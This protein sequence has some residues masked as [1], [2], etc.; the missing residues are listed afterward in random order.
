[1]SDV[2]E[3]NAI[4]LTVPPGNPEAL[5]AAI[6]KL[7]DNYQP[8][9]LNDAF[10]RLRSEYLWDKV[11]QPLREFCENPSA[12]PDKGQYLTEVERISK[13]KDQFLMKVIADKDDFWGAVVKDRDAVIER[14]RKS[15]PLRVYA[16]L[17]RFFG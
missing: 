9:S 11:V 15:L 8:G 6:V 2:V 13:D 14:Y 7:L 1:M 5:A 10:D 3:R 16:A 12:A 17:K 4:G